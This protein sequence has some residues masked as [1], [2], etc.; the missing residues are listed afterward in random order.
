MWLPT[1]LNKLSNFNGT[2]VNICSIM[3]IDDSTEV[4]LMDSVSIIHNMSIE[5]MK[6]CNFVFNYN[7]NA[8]TV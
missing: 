4:N 1:I 6:Q 7:R 3:T 2:N 5:L 8:M